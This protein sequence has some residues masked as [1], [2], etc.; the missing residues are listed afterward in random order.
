MFNIEWDEEFFFAENFFGQPQCLVCSRTL[1]RVEKFH[2]ERHYRTCHSQYI[3]IKN[4]ERI[5]LL[6]KCKKNFIE[7]VEKSHVHSWLFHALNGS[8]IFLQGCVPINTV[9]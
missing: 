9:A 7:Q 3:E 4:D 6:L 2:N 1:T 8:I 5:E